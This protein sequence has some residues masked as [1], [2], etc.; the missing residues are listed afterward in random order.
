M[1]MASKESRRASAEQGGAEK[2]AVRVMARVRPFN[3]RELGENPAKYPNSIIMMSGNTMHVLNEQGN[4]KDAFEFHECFW[5]IPPSQNQFS[6]N[7]FAD[8]IDVFNSTGTVAVEA[9]LKG[10]H[11][12][13]F[14]YGQTGSGKTYTMLGSEA[15]PG[16]APRLVDHLFQEMANAQGAGGYQYQVSIS[17]MEIYNEKVKDLLEES[18]RGDKNR[19]RKES[20]VSKRGSV[21][22]KGSD[23]STSHTSPKGKK[24]SN[25]LTKF[26]A[27][28]D[29]YQELRV[30]HSPAKG[31]FVEGLTC[32]DKSHGVSTA[33]DI[34]RAIKTGME[35]RA[36]AETK[37]NST[38]SR[39]HA[40]FQIHVVAKN[41]SKGSRRYA[42]INLVDLAGSER[43]KMSGAE[44]DRKIE[45]TKI[46]VSLST[47]R[48]VIDI[49]IENSQ[50]KKKEQKLVPPYRDSMLTWVL[51]ESLGGNSKT[52]MLATVSPYIGN[53]EDTVNTLRYA[54][55]AKAIV[56][57][58]KVNE[59]KASVL[60]SA[61]QAEIEALRQK[62]V[63][64]DMDANSC[65]FMKTELKDR[66]VE[67]HDIAQDT[68]EMAKMV[69]QHQTEIATKK[70]EVEQL[71]RE[72]AKLKTE[73]IEEKHEV[74]KDRY[75]RMESEAREA[76]RKADE[77]RQ[78]K[79]EAERRHKRE[80]AEKEKLA[81]EKEA[82][83]QR[84]RLF[85]GE[86]AHGRRKQ[87]SRAFQ[88][89]FTSERKS[90]R[91]AKLQ[92]DVQRLHARSSN[93]YQDIQRITQDRRLLLS[94]N[95]V[96]IEKIESV[97]RLH[98]TST[99]RKEK[100]QTMMEERLR[101]TQ[102]AKKF[103]EEDNMQLIRSLDRTLTELTSL[104]DELQR[105]RK[106][107]V[108]G[109]K[110]LRGKIETAKREKAVKAELLEELKRQS[111]L[112]ANEGASLQSETLHMKAASDHMR[113]TITQ[114]K[115]EVQELTNSNN[116]HHFELSEL[117][118]T[119]TTE[120]EAL[121]SLRNECLIRTTTARG[122]QDKHNDLKEIVSQRFFPAS[123]VGP[124]SSQ[125]PASA[126]TNPVITQ[127]RSTSPG[128]VRTNSPAREREWVGDTL[129][130][131]SRTL[132]PPSKRVPGRSPSPGA[133]TR[134]VPKRSTS[135]TIVDGAGALSGPMVPPRYSGKIR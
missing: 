74:A 50:K 102:H 122:L 85:R 65:N 128:Q 52:M 76:A 35:Y 81:E 75:K 42:H 41:A 99:V 71:R 89:A 7:P 26:D 80:Q 2:A 105:E 86:I 13:I 39:S 5:S 49:L 45:A 55:K 34:K 66:E 33:E 31:V 43:L 23:H 129:H 107:A 64:G 58:V 113:N 67:M 68:V 19:P 78:Q 14:A 123:S 72:E 91:L 77:M 32:L 126:S 96:V 48:R 11:C 30:R 103:A 62:I 60:V 84:N 17:F 37:M 22:R 28:D 36:T 114:R 109:E 83:D 3:S 12:C 73:R 10:Y 124:G 121:S 127:Q 21:P 46:N 130:Y 98:Q 1:K 70:R 110:A 106:L 9:A 47:L 69:E 90:E 94:A 61:M 53:I 117:T 93:I 59:E 44:G 82:V 57:T 24:R 125:A 40:I 6:S 104:K 87:F 131:T 133:V 100:D 56:N 115:S 8:Q 132:S 119:L 16:I 111:I 18:R 101:E 51:S 108:S 29:D 27:G 38:S 92:S 63:V 88:L 134:N 97:N 79:L 135:P 118:Q 20:F 4:M 25:T 95:E 120:R 15:N 116:K 112:I 54:L